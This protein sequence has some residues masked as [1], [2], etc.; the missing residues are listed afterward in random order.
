MGELLP[1]FMTVTWPISPYEQ[2]P[3][4]HHGQ[5]HMVS[6]QWWIRRER[7]RW[8]ARGIRAEIVTEVIDGQEYEVL[9][10]YG[11]RS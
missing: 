5:S 4:I 8:E 6:G 3:T 2:I 10:Q 7:N 11:P 9:E 1:L